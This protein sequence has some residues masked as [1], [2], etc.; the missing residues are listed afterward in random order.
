MNELSGQLFISQAT[1]DKT[2]SKITTKNTTQYVR[3][4]KL[5]YTIKLIDLGERKV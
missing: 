1:S 3:Y 4:F 5:Q 2:V